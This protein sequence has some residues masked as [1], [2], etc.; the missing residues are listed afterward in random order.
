M[1][2]SG[3][4]RVIAG[5]VQRFHGAD[6]FEI[7]PA[8]SYPDDYLQTVNQAAEETDRGFEPPLRQTIGNI[9]PYDLIFLGFPIWGMTAPPLIRSFLSNHNLS[10]KTIAPFITHGGY[11]IGQALQV[12]AAYAPEARIEEPFVMQRDQ[13]RDTLDPVS[14]WLS[15]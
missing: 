14:R 12:I 2:R 8:Q 6:V 4:T 11:G 1:S 13:E 10:G 5:Q 3:N 9:A 15:R 7:L